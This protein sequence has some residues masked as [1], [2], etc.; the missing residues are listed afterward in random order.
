MTEKY[1]KYLKELHQSRNN[2][3]NFIEIIDFNKKDYMNNLK[4]YLNL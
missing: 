3:K 1:T 2:L 4:N